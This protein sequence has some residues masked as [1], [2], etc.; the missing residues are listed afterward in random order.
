MTQFILH[1]FFESYAHAFLKKSAYRMQRPFHH[2]LE[3]SRHDNV[4]LSSVHQI[5]KRQV[6]FV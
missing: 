6:V 2:F 3:F 5:I 4:D 1:S